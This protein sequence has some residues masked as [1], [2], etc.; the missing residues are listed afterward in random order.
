MTHPK[1]AWYG[2]DLDGTL[3]MYDGWRG[4]T[5]IGDPIPAMI[6][7]VRCWLEA[8]RL[9]KIVTA[10]AAIDSAPVGIPAI[11]AWCVQ[12]VGQPLEVTCCKD[13]YMIELWDDRARQVEF[14][15][16]RAL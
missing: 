16:G 7:R 11:Q 9:V 10:R 3:A 2:V 6:A 14:N 8:G 5:H 12:H 15:T 1:Q 13:E 4:P